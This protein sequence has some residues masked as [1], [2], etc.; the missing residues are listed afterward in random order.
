MLE[1]AESV[2]QMLTLAKSSAGKRQ[3]ALSSAIFFRATPSRIARRLRT[4][5]AAP[6]SMTRNTDVDDAMSTRSKTRW[7]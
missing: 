6:T 3:F 2:E 7:S 1:W 4:H 5:P